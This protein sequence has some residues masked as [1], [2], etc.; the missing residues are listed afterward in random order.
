[1]VRKVF[2]VLMLASVILPASS[3]C[4]FAHDCGTAARDVVVSGHCG[5][6]PEQTTVPGPDQGRTAIVP[7]SMHD[8]SCCPSMEPSE[9]RPAVTITSSPLGNGQSVA[10]VWLVQRIEASVQPSHPISLNG[11][12]SSLP[13]P[14]QL[15]CLYS[16]YLI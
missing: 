12:V 6:R 8:A 2:I 16:S 10:L 5:D 14:R 7:F 3:V 9:A 1:M 4:A 11:L 15:Y 13:S